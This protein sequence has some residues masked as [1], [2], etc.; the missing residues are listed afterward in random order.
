M[1][2]RR[3]RWRDVLAWCI[4]TAVAFGA[5]LVFAGKPTRDEAIV[6]ALGAILAGT[7]SD[8]VR[9]RG[10]VFFEG[11]PRDVAQLWRL[12]KSMIVGTWQI[13]GVLLRQIFGGAPAES[14]LLWVP[15]EA[16]PAKDEPHARARRA[17]AVA[18]TTATPNVVVVGIDRERGRFV[19][20]QIAA[21]PL[22]EMTR[23]LGARPDAP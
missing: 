14:L 18:Y 1:S 6:G 9:R 5:Y 16:D 13:L 19:F 2:R 4:Q 10:V 17:L 3:S 21:G 15:Y 7:L 8:V 11:R 12:P 22:G 20:H 23:R